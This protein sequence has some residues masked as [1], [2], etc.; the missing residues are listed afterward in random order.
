LKEKPNSRDDRV[1]NKTPPRLEDFR[2]GKGGVCRRM[3]GMVS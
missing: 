3:E 1:G 2:K